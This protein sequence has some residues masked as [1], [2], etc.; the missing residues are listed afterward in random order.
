[1][2]SPDPQIGNDFNRRHFLSMVGKGVGLAALS[3]TAV[4]SLLEDLHAATKRVEHLSPTEAAMN[5]DFWFE[6]QR[7]FSITRG[8]T[9][10]NNGGV[11]PSP[12]IVTE[13]LCRY[14]W[15][16]E[17]VTAYTMWSILEPQS[18]TVRTGL[19]EIY[20]CDREEIA[21]TRNASESLEIILMGMDLKSG[22][23]ILT[24]TQDYP[25]M[26]TTL[27]QREQREGL[28]LR[29][30]KVPIAP[31]HLDDITAEFEKAISPKTRVILISH[32]INLTGQVM[33]VK[34]I[35]ALAKSKGIEVIVDGA[36]AF[37][38]FDF[39]QSDLGCDYY[40]TSLHKWL[41]APKGTGLLF[42]K[43]DKIEKIWPLMAADKSQKNDIRKFEEIGTHPA[44]PRL[45]IGEAILYHN[46]IGA[47]RKEERLRYLSRY[48]MTKLKDLPN[49]RFHTSWEPNQSCGIANVEIVGVDPGA[50]GTYLM[51][52]HK[53]LT[54]AIIHDEFKGIRITPSVYT[55]L[56]ELD[57]FSDVMESVAKKGLPKS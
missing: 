43:R 18:E 29:M 24:T 15:Q 12:R 39:K 1:M 11:S 54:T 42:V 6:I 14:I 7:S 27:R 57:R 53:I 8:I 56:K 25:R 3:S 21:I 31:D 44:A 55:T 4:A 52:K 28:I 30:I 46:G 45:A 35:C 5:E 49:I 34:S 17:D 16:Q 13:A 26:L 40:G 22:D 36:H 2:T 50:L 41:F 9:N 20:G 47:K 51:D 32:V 23:E 48:W 19:A 10:L 38:H 37:A 33:P